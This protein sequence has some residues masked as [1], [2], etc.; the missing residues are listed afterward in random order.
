MI[1][2]LGVSAPLTGLWVLLGVCSGLVLLGTAIVAWLELQAAHSERN[3]RGATRLK[4]R[5]L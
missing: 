5:R 1:S 3:R 2:F 4:P